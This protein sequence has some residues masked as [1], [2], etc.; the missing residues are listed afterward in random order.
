MVKNALKHIRS[1]SM[2][3]VK[4]KPD[5]QP[6][7][8]VTLPDTI[9]APNKSIFTTLLPEAKLHTLLKYVEGY[10]WTIDY[11]GQI[12]NRNNTLEHF[13]PSTPNL[14][15]PYY[16]VSKLIVQVSSTLSSSYDQTTGLT[17]IT[18]SAIAPLGLIPNVGDLFIA[19]VDTGEDAIFIITTVSRKT[20]RKDTLYEVSYSLYSYTSA[21]PEFL[22]TLT[23][24][25]NDVYFFNPDTNF[26]NRDVL[27]KPS[28]KEAK[29]RLNRFLH[30]SKDYYFSKFL[31]T[32]LGTIVIP[33]MSHSLYD[34]HLINF[35]F[36]TVKFDQLLKKNFFIHSVSDTQLSQPSIL[37]CILTCSK[38]NINTINRTYKYIP[39]NMIANRARFG[40]VFH[41]GIEY[42]LYPT[43]PDK[44]TFYD[45]PRV[46]EDVES[47]PNIINPR[48][49]TG[50]NPTI[51]QSTNNNQLYTKPL[52]HNLF[53]D[54]Y[55]IVSRNFYSYLN[56]NES[57]KD[58]SYIELLLSRFLQHKA[59]PREDLAIT[60]ERYDEW[61]LIHQI[62]LLPVLWHFIQATS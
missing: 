37:H 35:L 26:F 2:S 17:T 61:P 62:Y 49:N 14:T 45:V 24:R 19:Q 54:D 20:H 55:Y 4:L 1:I 31:D 59:I 38:S 33:G 39:S 40:T 30:E 9:E 3:I 16:K 58:I 13:D 32:N 23:Q 7:I 28:V 27:I 10:P 41:A 21:R 52:L 25:I 6:P 60:V 11:Y 56:N 53:E 50:L 46:I 51:T 57:Y 48:N 22:T 47:L 42:I 43:D 29:D 5:A 36:R 18:G 44:R 8:Q 12:L 34:S 15:Q